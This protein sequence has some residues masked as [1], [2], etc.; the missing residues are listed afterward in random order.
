MNCLN[1]FLLFLYLI[2]NALEVYLKLPPPSTFLAIMCGTEIWQFMAHE[3]AKSLSSWKFFSFVFEARKLYVS[4]PTSQKFF[5]RIFEPPKSFF[6][7]YTRQSIPTVD[8]C[9]WGTKIIRVF[10]YLTKILCRSILTSP[11]YVSA[12][13]R[14]TQIRQ[15]MADDNYLL[16]RVFLCI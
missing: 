4:L 12:I 13:I 6:S 7:N 2:K 8:G 16:S 5:A 15:L 3:A 10:L 1:Y 14:V 9:F 11:P